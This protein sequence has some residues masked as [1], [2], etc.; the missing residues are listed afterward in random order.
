MTICIAALYKNG[1][2][3]ILA[4]DRMVT[5]HFPMGYEYEN[6]EVKKIIENI[7]VLYMHSYQGMSFS[8]TRLLIRQNRKLLLQKQ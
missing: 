1:E 5:V 3:C 8:L 4:S 7:L 6:E 2:G